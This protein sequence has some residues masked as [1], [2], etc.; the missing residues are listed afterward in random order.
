LSLAS[1]LGSQIPKILVA[2]QVE[3]LK[4]WA[5]GIEGSY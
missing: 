5:L 4:K 3:G 1:M 2:F